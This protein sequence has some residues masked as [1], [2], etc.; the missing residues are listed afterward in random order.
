MSIIIET[1]V[2]MVRAATTN[3]EENMYPIYNIRRSC[4]DCGLGFG[5]LKKSETTGWLQ[6]VSV[7]NS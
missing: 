1:K 5:L 6:K 3:V 7:R 2:I 4:I